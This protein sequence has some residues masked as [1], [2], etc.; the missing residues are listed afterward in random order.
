MRAYRDLCTLVGCDGIVKVVV[1]AEK[2]LA[3]E[4]RGGS[5]NVFNA[6]IN[7]VF[8]IFFY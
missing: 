3:F 4:I 2:C 7:I 8:F 6:Y 1:R 5:D